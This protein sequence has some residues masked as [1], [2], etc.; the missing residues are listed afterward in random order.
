[1]VI[2]ELAQ[3]PLPLG[4]QPYFEVHIVHPCA[5]DLDHLQ[6]MRVHSDDVLYLELYRVVKVLV[7]SPLEVPLNLALSDSDVLLYEVVELEGFHLGEAKSGQVGYSNNEHVPNPHR[8]NIL[9]ER[10]VILGEVV[11]V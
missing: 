2:E 9:Y 10:D 7:E 11:L 3:I 1:M 6:V 4:P 5:P 8:Q